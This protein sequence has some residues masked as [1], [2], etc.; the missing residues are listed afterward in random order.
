MPEGISRQ[1]LQWSTIVILL[2]PFVMATISLNFTSLWLLVKC[3]IPF[4]LFLPTLVGSFTMYS[5]ARLA[6][7]SWGNRVSVAG[8]NFKAAS[9]HEIALVQEDLSNNSLVALIFLTFINGVIEFLVIYYG[10]D[11]WFIIGVMAFIFFSTIMLSMISIVY[12]IGKH[13]R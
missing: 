8:T 1:I 5:M 3:S 4:W 12:F 7:T 11:T 9:Q 2:I 10:V 6:D 13:I